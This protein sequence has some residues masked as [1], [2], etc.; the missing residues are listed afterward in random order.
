MNQLIVDSG[1]KERIHDGI[2]HIAERG[3]GGQNP[4][5]HRRRQHGPRLRRRRRNGRRFRVD[6]TRLRDD[7]ALRAVGCGARLFDAVA[8]QRRPFPRQRHRRQRQRTRFRA[9]A[10]Q[11]QHSRGAAPA[12]VGAQRARH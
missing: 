3:R 12:A 4:L 1:G 5:R 7:D 9:A 11:R 6:G 2:S 10:L 8:G